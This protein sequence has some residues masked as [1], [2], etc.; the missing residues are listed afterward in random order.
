[1]FSILM[2]HLTLAFRYIHGRPNS[3]LIWAG[4]AHVGLAVPGKAGS[5]QKES[6]V[7]I[8]IIIACIHLNFL[9]FD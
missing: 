1:M 8:L 6:K 3:R 9:R 2:T 7:I 5:W 4:Y